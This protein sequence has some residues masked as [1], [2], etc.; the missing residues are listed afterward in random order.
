M[1]CTLCAHDSSDL[2]NVKPA[3]CAA[4]GDLDRHLAGCDR[5]V[6]ATFGAVV[7]AAQEQRHRRPAVDS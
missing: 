3:G 6:R 4:L 1:M 5:V 2:V 7:A